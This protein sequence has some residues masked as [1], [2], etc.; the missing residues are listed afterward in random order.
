IQAHLNTVHAEREARREAGR[1]GMDQL[2]YELMH[3]LVL[4]TTRMAI[5]VKN[6]KMRVESLTARLEFNERRSR[7]LESVVVYRP[8][9]GERLPPPTAIDPPAPSPRRAGPEVA[10]PQVEVAAAPPADAA[11][12]AASAE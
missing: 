7:A 9:D 5:E 6:L 12:A 11:A 10:A 2:Q 3:N 4:E 8:A 1:H